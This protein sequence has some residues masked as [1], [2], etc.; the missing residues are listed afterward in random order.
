MCKKGLR[1]DAFALRKKTVVSKAVGFYTKNL[2][3]KLCRF[4]VRNTLTFGRNA[5]IIEA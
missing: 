1:M 3:E 4:S 5:N 2:I